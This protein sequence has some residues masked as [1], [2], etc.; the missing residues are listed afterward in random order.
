MTNTI[1]I[2][3]GVLIVAF[4]AADYFYFDMAMSFLL[5]RKL[6]DMIEYMAFWR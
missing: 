3:L 1:S 2:W 6:L 4:F 5:S